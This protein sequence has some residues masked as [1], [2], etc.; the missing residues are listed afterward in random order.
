MA[1]D[2]GEEPDGQR[3]A[4]RAAAYDRGFLSTTAITPLVFV[5]GVITGFPAATIGVGFLLDANVFEGA[6][7][8]SIDF[9]GAIVLD[10]G[11]LEK[12]QAA[13]QGQ[14]FVAER[15]S[16]EPVAAEAVSDHPQFLKIDEALYEALEDGTLT[17]FRVVRVGEFESDPGRGTS[18]YDR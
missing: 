17:P 8:A 12:L 4:V 11:F 6:N 5:P 9:S 10:E 14:S 2:R 13:S 16:L 1:E 3:V 15:F 18:V 7:L